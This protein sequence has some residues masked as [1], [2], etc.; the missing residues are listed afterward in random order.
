MKDQYLHK[1][2]PTPVPV[3][4]AAV[5]QFWTVSRT[6]PAFLASAA[7]ALLLVP[8]FLSLRFAFAVALPLAILI[9]LTSHQVWRLILNPDRN[10]VLHPTTLVAAYFLLYFALRTYY[11]YAVPFF[12]RMGRNGYDDAIPA[13]LWCACA[14]FVA[15]SLGMR[16]SIAKRWV[17]RV[18]APSL[19]WSRGLPATRLLLLMLVGL[20]SLI[21]LFR[22]G[23]VVGN[24]QN[25]AFERNPPPGIVVLMENTCDL[26]WVAICVYLL[27]PVKKSRTG[28]VWLLFGLSVCILGVKLAISG[29]KVSLI[30]PLMEAAIVFHYCKR[31]FRIWELVIVGVPV[32]VLAFG[33]VNFYRFVVVGR[34][35]A[36][37]SVSDVVSRVSM[38]SDLMKEQRGTVGQQSALEQMVE[39]DA[40]TDAL[41]LFIKYTPHPFPYS[42]GI[43]WL[44]LPLTFIPRQIWKSKPIDMPSAEFES[45]YMGEH[46]GYNGFSSMHLIGDMYRNFSWPGAVAGMFILGVFLRFFYLFSSPGPDNHSG[47]FLYAALFPEILHA[48]E[49][50]AGFALIEVTRSALLAI[51]V[52][53]FLGQ[54]FAQ[55][56]RAQST[57]RRTAVVRRNNRVA[58]P[59]TDLM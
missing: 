32:V 3:R 35:G 27:A 11:L 5:R 33:V 51:C 42:Y 8:Y 10:D 53:L 43:H 54:R 40:G 13:A 7:L 24:Y 4:A 29:G 15:F 45:T 41:A 59:L 44:Q 39:R 16:S 34:H 56:G 21:Y 31:R 55:F 18:P 6:P 1:V 47:L 12:P 57:P 48:L 22:I 49:S 28:I 17:K 50:D 46:I 23:Q 38:A 20:G 19:R 25:L 26:S 58:I 9:G 37:K 36:P 14:G 2:P 30:Q 52:A